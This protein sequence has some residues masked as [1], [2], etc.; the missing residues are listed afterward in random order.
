MNTDIPESS[1]PE[2]A[3]SPTPET[4]G[5]D[6][7][8]DNRPLHD[9]D[10]RPKDRLWDMLCILTLI[11]GGS[12]LYIYG[13][14]SYS[15]WDPWEPKYAQTVIEMRQ[16]GEYITPY[17]EG[18]VR[19]TKP[20]FVYW[21]MMVPMSIGG[22]TELMARL[23]S[24]VAAVFGLLLLFYVVRRL[25]D[26]RTGMMAACILGTMPQYFY[27]ARQAMPDMLLTV[28]LIGALG[29]FA[30]GRF[31]AEKRPWHMRIGYAFVALAVLTKG[32][33]AGA[34]VVGVCGLFW[35]IEFVP[36][37]HLHWRR[38]PAAL[39]EMIRFYQVIPG[40]VIFVLLT[41]PWY[42]AMYQKHRQEFVDKA[43]IYENIERFSTPIRDHTGTVSYYFSTIFHGMYPWCGLL[44][45]ALCGVLFGFRTI[46]DDL[47]KR[48]FFVAWFLA[49][50]LLFTMAGTKLQHYLLPIAPAVAVLI[51]LVWRAWFQANMP[52]WV[53]PAL[54]IS[55]LFLMLPIRDFDL[56]GDRWLWDNFTNKRNIDNFDV[57][58]FLDR[59]LIIWTIGM[60]LATL[61]NRSRIIAGAT[62]LIAYAN[63]MYFC[64]E[65]MPT[66]D[67]G[68]SMA[69]YVEYYKSHRA[70]ETS[71]LA[72]YGKHR[73]STAYYCYGMDDETLHYYSRSEPENLARFA[74]DQTEIYIITEKKHWQRLHAE[75]QKH[76]GKSWY[77]VS[78]E[79][80]RYWLVTNTPKDER[81]TGDIP[82]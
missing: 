10:Q 41:A 14:G 25:F 51:A 2:P 7:A 65:V 32:P 26:R 81:R 18:Q 78:R 44:P 8:D 30:V 67:V 69:A 79:H 36:R 3:S 33:V 24:A 20:I 15:L 35:L 72:F 52:F 71:D 23:P 46:N 6:A 73:Y 61:I 76:S 45:V 56:E 64:H 12:F 60:L 57:Q 16:H 77:Y 80:P 50:F 48:W 49:V 74:H 34:I 47:R 63:G 17:Y 39:W 9:D 29:L 5:A 66:Q 40:T 27:L 54:L 4:L 38:G 1:G 42:I 62:V 28:F 21:A 22:D 37:T 58:P 31:D 19:W 43:I 68:R 70:D 53:R 11:I 55:I 75:L 13:A 82:E 59:L